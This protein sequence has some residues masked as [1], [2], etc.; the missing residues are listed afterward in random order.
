MDEGWV[1]SRVKEAVVLNW[2]KCDVSTPLGEVLPQGH[3]G[4]TNLRCVI[5]QGQGVVELAQLKIWGSQIAR[6]AGSAPFQS[7][8]HLLSDVGT[9]WS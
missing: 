1:A 2:L 6:S 5:F 7:M 3:I 9:F 4:G 8:K